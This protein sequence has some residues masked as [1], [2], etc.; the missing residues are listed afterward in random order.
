MLWNC[1]GHLGVDK[2]WSSAST[3]AAMD[4]AL[5]CTGLVR[6]G[7]QQHVREAVRVVICSGTARRFLGHGTSTARLPPA[8]GG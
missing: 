1:S 8:Q 7:P 4:A 6:Y 3:M 5:R 2:Q